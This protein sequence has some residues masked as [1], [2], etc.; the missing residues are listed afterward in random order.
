MGASTT[1]SR[2]HRPRGWQ[3]LREVVRVDILEGSQGPAFDQ[4]AR[5][6]VVATSPLP[7]PSDRKLFDRDLVF[8]CPV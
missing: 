4:V 3:H 1:K 6:A 7:P 5:R 8:A 2:V